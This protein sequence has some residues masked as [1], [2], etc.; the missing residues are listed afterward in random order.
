M[1][2]IYDVLSKLHVKATGSVEQSVEED[3]KKEDPS[4][5]KAKAILGEIPLEIKT[6]FKEKMKSEPTPESV[7]ENT[8]GND[9]E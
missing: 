9:E 6:V 1:T 5:E 4:K 8:K 2:N 7:N 3:L